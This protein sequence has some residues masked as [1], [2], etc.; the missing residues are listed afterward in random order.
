MYNSN[1]SVKGV[2]LIHTIKKTHQQ[3]HRTEPNRTVSSDKTMILPV[4]IETF[5][6]QMKTV[7]SHMLLGYGLFIGFTVSHIEWWWTWEQ[8]FD[9]SMSLRFCRNRQKQ[10][11]RS[12]F[13]PTN[14]FL[15][16]GFFQIALKTYHVVVYTICVFS[17]SL[18][19][20]SLFILF[21]EGVFW[22]SNRFS[23]LCL[24]FDHITCIAQ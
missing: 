13:I 4:P 21:N 5:H 12:T 22:F 19:S 24:L 9:S 15:T 11:H 7:E 23:L 1:F 3:Q 8:S 10:V 6:L 14:C 2:H 17:V 16:S 20:L 18:S